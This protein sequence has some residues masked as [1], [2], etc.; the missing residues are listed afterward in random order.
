M[1]AEIQKTIYSGSSALHGPFV[2][3]EW[4][5]L[6]PK[7]PPQGHLWPLNQNASF[8]TYKKMEIIQKAETATEALEDGEMK[9]GSM[10]LST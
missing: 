1:Q 6:Q 7:C 8:N 2:P 9:D 5:Y 4:R 10:F 3:Q